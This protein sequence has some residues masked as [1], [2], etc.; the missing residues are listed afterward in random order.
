MVQS[1]ASYHK[2]DSA[3]THKQSDKPQDLLQP[4][5]AQRPIKAVRCHVY[6]A[7]SSECCSS[8]AQCLRSRACETFFS[9]VS[10]SHD[11]SQIGRQRRRYHGRS[12]E[13]ANKSL[14][15]LEARHHRIAEGSQSSSQR[16]TFHPSPR[17]TLVSQ[18]I[19]LTFPKQNCYRSFLR[20]HRTQHLSQK[21][22][23]RNNPSC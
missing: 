17:S 21:A 3:T 6:F 14:A 16:R 15:A 5:Y 13:G 23:L 20:M 4:H 9:T 22:G 19:K 2:L 10:E 1:F 11:A 7:T 12:F 18:R 8:S